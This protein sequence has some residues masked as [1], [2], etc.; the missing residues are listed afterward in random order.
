MHTIA[1][2]LSAARL[3]VP[4]ADYIMMLIKTDLEKLGSRT[5]FEKM[6]IY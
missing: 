2:V 5:L 3:S 1:S 4:K 6:A